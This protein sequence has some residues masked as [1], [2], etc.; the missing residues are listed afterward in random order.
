MSMHDDPIQVRAALTRGASGFVVKEAAPAELEIALRAA[1]NGRTFLSPQVSGPQLHATR[2]PAATVPTPCPAASAKSWSH[3]APAARPS[4][5]QPTWASAPRPSRRTAR[6]S[7]K[8]WAVAIRWN[9]CG[10]HCACTTGTDTLRRTASGFS[11]ACRESPDMRGVFPD[12]APGNSRFG[13]RR[14]LRILIST[15]GEA[16]GESRQG[17]SR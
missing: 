14:R 4:R 10:W 17:K 12:V 13:I 7:W 3:S 15:A 5:S 1:V 6:G 11:R 16:V 2:K 9:C 8:P